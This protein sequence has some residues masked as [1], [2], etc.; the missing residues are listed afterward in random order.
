MKPKEEWGPADAL[1]M[2][3]MFGFC[4]FLSVAIGAGIVAI[5]MHRF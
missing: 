5:I 2:G 3:I 4:G 1:A